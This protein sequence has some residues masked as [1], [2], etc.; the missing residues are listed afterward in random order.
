MQAVAYAAKS[1]EDKRGSIKTQLDDCRSMAERE[2]WAVVA[3]YEDESKSAFSR[4]RGEGL[5]KARVHAERL[6]AEDGEAVLVVQHTDRLA[7]G[8][9]IQAAH[10][11]EI[12]LWAMKANVRVRSV[13][14]DRTGES[15]LDAAL[16]GTRNFED[17]KR[18]SESIKSGK[19]RA[20][21]QGEWH[22]GDPPD[23][24]ALAPGGGLVIDPE[25]APVIRRI[26]E[27]AL[28][29]LGRAA[30]VRR[31]NAERLRT[32]PIPSGKFKHDGLP[33]TNYRVGDV[34]SNPTYA[35]RTVLHRHDPEVATEPRPA[36]WEPIIDPADFDR[37]GMKAEL[38]RYKPSQG[39]PT[40]RYALSHLAVCDAC[41]RPMYG[42]TDTHVRKDGTQRRTYTCASRKENDSLCEVPRLDADL[43]DGA[44][45]EHLAGEFVDFQ[46]WAREQAEATAQGRA[47]IESELA[48]RQK[49]LR[50][51]QRDRDRV[52]K[53]YI[54]KVTPAR[55]D[56]LEA[57]LA[58][59]SDAEA[60]V[61]EVEQRLATVSDDI[62]TD[63]MLDVY[64]SL[65]AA[66]EDDKAPLN[67]RFQR[68]FSEVRVKVKGDA[69]GV[70]PILRPDVYEVH[71]SVVR[72][73]VGGDAMKHWATVD[74]DDAP[75]WTGGYPDRAPVMLLVPPPTSEIVLSKKDNRAYARCSCRGE[76]A[77][78][79]ATTGSV[80]LRR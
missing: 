61:A 30:I 68:I 23:G 51:A 35:A 43:I 71:G 13:Q 5:A 52:R 49:A 62:P 56:A 22:G 53:A 18:K 74:A 16:I 33:W 44:I 7:R 24:Y 37:V 40:A 79:P 31:L 59:V 27:L 8:D 36:K 58:T 78:A 17:S 3:T 57:A 28:E 6:A 25:R 11:V 66:L 20:Y 34:L 1:S 42:S 38:R 67:E 29:G 21:E 9:A 39:R 45:I 72:K 75:M 54:E 64:G 69:I 14:D 26:F 76:L 4:S 70:L 41:G 10:L 77:S 65:R 48:R 50:K 2:G 12:V 47:L 80:S 15:I 73:L 19:Q 46:K 60:A 63:A 55:E 32:R